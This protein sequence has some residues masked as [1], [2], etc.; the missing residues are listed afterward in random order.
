M[1]TP[2]RCPHPDCPRHLDPSPRFF[3]RWGHYKPRCRSFW[4]PRFR[5]RTCRRTFSRQTFRSDYRDRR[6]GVNCAVLEFVTSGVGLRQSGRN[7]ALSVR[8]MQKKLLKIARHLG[9]LHDNLAAELPPRRTYALDEEETFEGVSI[10][11]LTVPLLVETESWFLVG[12]AVGTIRRLARAGSR[13]RR[14]QDAEER[15][16]GRREDQSRAR[17]TDVLQLLR[18]RAPKGRL[19]IR[20]D[21]KS[22]YRTVIQEVFGAR[23][24]HCTTSGKDE[25]TTANPLFPVNMTIAMSRDNCGRLRRQS[26][27]FAKTADGLRAQLKAY[28]AYRNYVRVR[29]NRDEPWQ[30]AACF[31]GLAPRAL[32]W[33]EVLR[34]RQDWGRRSIHPISRGA[35]ST[36]DSVRAASA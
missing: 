35:R 9:Q 32:H 11:P 19:T 28:T 33:P 2:P 22:S 12:S 26:W 15:A 29:F 1:F 25:R 30:S 5:C 36:I 4:I 6:P 34:W 20:S 7:R 24:T 10:R 8:G 31:L 27:L 13:R 17:V 14:L 16:H 3:Y 23:A 18:Q 21:E